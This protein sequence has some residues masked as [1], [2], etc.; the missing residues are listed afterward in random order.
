MSL[1]SAEIKL[2]AQQLGFVKVGIVP[3]TALEA[4]GNLL[5]QW[6]AR[7]YHGKMGYMER[8][9]ARRSDPRLLLPS[10]RSVI[11]LAFNYHTSQQHTDEPE[12]GKIS[13]YA[14]G[15]DYHDVLGGKLA[16]LIAWF[17]QKDSTLEAKA[18]VDAGP[19]MDKA[20]AV[21]A[22]IGWLGKHTNVISREYGSWLFLAEILL[23]IELDYDQEVVAD[24]C[25]SCTNC[26][27]AC[28][29]EA[30]VAPYLLDAS[31]CI[32]YAT[33][34]LK[35]KELPPSIAANLNN[36]IF[37]CDICQDVCPWNRF[38]QQTTET[39]FQPRSENL[40]PNLDELAR[41]SATE[42]KQRYQNS[43]ITRPK[44]EGFLRNVLAAQTDTRSVAEREETKTYS[45]DNDDKTQS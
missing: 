9:A 4:E 35:D 2:Y 29:T 31:R 18:Y 41:L 5:Q 27:E 3:A 38:A 40:S 43:P 10:V 7:G 33:I 17:K 34:E 6:L 30:I 11:S 42:F 16:E 12:V 44:Y 20:W 19:M 1:N 37:G 45:A 32:S 39:A 8:G 23:N 22:G 14:W 24:F 15:D 25:G 13:R 26:I 21:R 28:P 36:W